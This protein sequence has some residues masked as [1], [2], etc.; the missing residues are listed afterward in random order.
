MKYKKLQKPNNKFKL[1]I[2]KDINFTIK[3][4]ENPI[5]QF[6]HEQTNYLLYDCY[7]ISRNNKVFDNDCYVQLPEKTVWK[8]LFEMLLAKNMLETKNIKLRIKKIDNFNYELILN[9]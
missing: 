5:K 2:G 3:D 6:K 1:T 4:F 8:K 7:V 9:T